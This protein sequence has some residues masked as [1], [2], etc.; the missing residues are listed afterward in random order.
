[1][2]NPFLLDYKSRLAA[3]KTCR[4]LIKETPDVSDALDVCLNFWRQAPLENHLLNW[5]NHE[6]WPTMW[7]MLNTNSYCTSMHSLGIAETLRL[8]DHRWD[9]TQLW[10]IRDPSAHVEK[11]VTVYDSWVLNHGYLDKQPLVQLQHVYKQSMW[12][13]T[14]KHWQLK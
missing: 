5:D 3:W 11:V 1:M 9:S 13:H 14:G 10:L 6:E 2:I 4:T 12:S 7:Q 8:S